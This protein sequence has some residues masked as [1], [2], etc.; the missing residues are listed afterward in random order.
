MEDESGLT[1]LRIN[2]LLDFFGAKGRSLSCPYCPHEGGWDIA[3]QVLDPEDESNPLLVVFPN[4]SVSGTKHAS[5]GLTCPNC[6]HF[7]LVSTYTIR[8]Y[9]KE[10]EDLNG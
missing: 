6:G 1:P 10:A 4:A 5:C 3:L 9:L 7:T 8:E 2:D